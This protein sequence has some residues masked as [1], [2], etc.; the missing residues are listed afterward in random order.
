MLTIDEARCIAS[1]ISLT[2]HRP[3]PYPSDAAPSD[4]FIGLL[5]RD[6]RFN[7]E[8]YATLHAFF[9]AANEQGYT[10]FELQLITNKKRRLELCINPRG[11][12]GM[13]GKFELRGNMICAA[14]EQDVPTTI[15]PEVLI[16]YGGTRSGEAP[17]QR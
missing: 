11:R 6:T 9:L 14:A 16:N 12:S 13:R 17:V 3:E 1:K 10:N 5:M 15:D 7:G 2:E 4:V 8:H